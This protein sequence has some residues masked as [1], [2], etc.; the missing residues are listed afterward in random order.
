[1]LREGTLPN[2]LTLR[3]TAGSP[4]LLRVTVPV[5]GSVSEL[6]KAVAVTVALPKPLAGAT[7]SQLRD[8][9]RLQ[10]L[11]EVMEKVPTP[12]VSA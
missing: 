8:S 10:A 5:R 11:L 12:P 7:L 2:W 6:A 4:G 1:M 3:V 9:A